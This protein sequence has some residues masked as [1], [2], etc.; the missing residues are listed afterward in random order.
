M[1]EEGEGMGSALKIRDD[2]EPAELRRLARQ[3]TD[4]RVARRLVAIANALEGM[5]RR[6]AAALAGM[7]RQSLRDWV[8][9]FNAEGV[10]GLGDR[11][12]PGRPPFLT[13]WQRGVLKRLILRGPRPEHDGVSAGR[14][15][16][17]CELVE[18]R[19]GVV[20]QERGMLSLRHSLGLSWQK[21]RPVPP[22]A[23]AAA[24]AA[25]KRGVWRAE[26]GGS[27]AAIPAIR[28]N[29]GARMR[30]A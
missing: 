3:E 1:P 21:P 23:D 10:E 26:S 6:A 14:V 24:Q 16:D 7:D 4:G 20:Y 2:L 9:R 18:R 28:S 29:S 19:F 12:R 17:I 11:P 27:P 30:P 8:I 22:Q 5:S 13:V 25:F 15:S